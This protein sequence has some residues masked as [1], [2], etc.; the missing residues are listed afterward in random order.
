[1]TQH[2]YLMIRAIIV[3]VFLVAFSDS[4]GSSYI[5]S[6]LDFSYHPLLRSCSRFFLPTGYTMKAVFIIAALLA[7][8]ALVNAVSSEK[9][10]TDVEAILQK[11][12]L[13]S[14]KK[15]LLKQ[16]LDDE[17]ADED[18]AMATVMTNALMSG[19]LEPGDDGEESIM[20]SI[21]SSNDEE[22]TAQFR[23]LRRLIERVKPVFR[24]IR[25]SRFGKF[26]GKQ[27]RNR[28]CNRGK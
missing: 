21:M 7:A 4:P 25:D 16:D 19:L 23:F 9:E 14:S 1:M 2:G 27:I 24:R 28:V 10:T 12:G 15:N 20:A 5:R 17:L 13:S 8:L 3:I 22:A 18:E 11:L 26:I 6:L